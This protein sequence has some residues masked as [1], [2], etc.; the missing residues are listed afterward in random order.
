MDL[1]EREAA[2]EAIA[3][4]G[5]SAY[6]GRGGAVCVVAPA[7]VGKTSFLAVAR[8]RLAGVGLRVLGV[9]AG[10]HERSLP[11]CVTRAL[12]EPALTPEVRDRVLV[13]A[14]APARTL[15]DG[16]AAGSLSHALYWTVANL[17]QVGP[18]A[19]VV[20]D[21]HWADEASLEMLTYLAR[22]LDDLP[23]L[24]LVAT[25]PEAQ[26]AWPAPL[27]GLHRAAAELTLEPLSADGTAAFV[28]AVIG[29][30]PSPAFA[31][32]CH[33]ATGGVP[34]YLDELVRDV[35]RRGGEP[36]DTEAGSVARIVP[37]AIVRSVLLRL[38]ALGPLAPHLARAAAVLGDG[39]RL[40][41][42]AALAGLDLDDA[43]VAADTLVAGGILT[44][45]GIGFVHPILR[46]AVI[47]DIGPHARARAHDR[48]ARLLDE[49]RAPVG[50]VAAHLLQVEPAADPWV[51]ATLLAAAREAMA[52]GSPVTS[53]E[54]LRRAQ[55]EPPLPEVQAE[56]LFAL[57]VAEAALG[58]LA[59]LGHLEAS[60][61]GTD[62]PEARAA[63]ALVI[64]ELARKA[65]LAEQGIA[66]L[67]MALAVLDPA[68]AEGALASIERYWIGRTTLPTLDRVR[69]D[70]AALDRAAVHPDPSVRRHAAVYL[71]M[72]A[73][74]DGTRAEVDRHLDVALDHP[75]LGRCVPPDGG[76]I[77]AAFFTLCTIERYDAFDRLAD[78]VLAASGR[79]GN[80]VGHVL[81]TLWRGIALL[82]RG[83]LA[84]AGH[85]ARDAFDFA[86][87]HGW[88]GG[89]PE[90]VAVRVLASLRRGDRGAAEVAVRDSPFPLEVV[91]L[92]PQAMLLDARGQVALAHGDA[93][94]ALEDA[95]RAGAF[96][97]GV[98]LTNPGYVAWRSTAA[99]AL[100]QLGDLGSARSLAEEQVALADARSGPAT[101]AAARRVLAATLERDA[102]LPVLER[103]HS[104]A[105]AS[106]AP[107][108]R[109]LVAADLGAALRRSGRTTQARDVLRVA[110]QQATACGM[111]PLVRQVREEVLAAGGRPRR[112]AVTGPGA[113]TASELRVARMAAGGLT[114]TIIAQTLFV[115][116]KT[117]EK[118][119]ANAY[120]KLGI[121]S[122]AELAAVDLDP[123]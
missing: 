71:A 18:L 84:E 73:A 89:T 1:L 9:A 80:G 37:A 62:D 88:P 8:E 76:V 41:D 33:E 117:V 34:F 47:D 98:G 110:L 107:G 31:A 97:D 56:H 28:A 52:A 70:R 55:Q 54:L 45:G 101:R 87:E 86:V 61:A 42:A 105:V 95:R 27:M 51:C 106:A 30:A 21:A 67:D 69:S 5:A 82:H 74:L 116:R 90:L 121:A 58:D 12:L 66:A 99:E 72:E 35:L 11:H 68:S 94:S 29:R 78:D 122:R 112:I 100:R 102:A 103:A 93:A 46:A 48:A 20:D 64:G 109:A 81:A 83:L 104:L 118:H 13:D 2:L 59:A 24:L 123:S 36:V 115:S 57:G 10:E 79:S 14:A 44:R 43:A 16:T 40:A 19:L 63:R 32:A 108:E 77:T 39:A 7:G 120:A 15:L 3:A 25:R 111:D 96:L 6:A 38:A 53:A 65:G 26:A 114:N 85:E 75:G 49:R 91:E 4:H 92:A 23:V 60:I 22:R 113:L 17:G 50:L 119:L